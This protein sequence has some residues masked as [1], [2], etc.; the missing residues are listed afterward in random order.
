MNDYLDAI[1]KNI[2]SMPALPLT[3]N[4]V[5]EVCRKQEPTAIE[6]NK[7]ISL[8]PI[9]TGRVIKLVNSAY[10]ALTQ[11][12]TSIVKAVIMLGIN[13]IKNVALSTAVVPMVSQY[14]NALKDTPLKI[15]GFWKHS[16]AVGITAKMIARNS[17]IESNKIEEYFIAGLLHDIGK[18]IMNINLPE[19]YLKALKISD[20]K[21]IPL[22]KA[23]YMIMQINHSEIGQLLAEKWGISGQ[24]K[25]AIINHHADQSLIEEHEH[26]IH[27]INIADS[28]CNQNQIGYAGNR[29]PEQID[30]ELLRK[31]NLDL[32][33]LFSWK[34]KI[35][36][37]LVKAQVF[38]KIGE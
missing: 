20:E 36:E 19:D 14:A 21:K 23:E 16:I 18:L 38:M 25:S 6:L 29:S 2:D 9:L 10:Y 34:E 7:I 27:S 26:L 1:L 28:F 35:K 32:E 11:E 17:K 37:E 4:K 31:M 3:V 13:T 33:T 30:K 12:C 8:D 24:I 5:L 22:Y 15:E